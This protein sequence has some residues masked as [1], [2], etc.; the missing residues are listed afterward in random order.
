MPICFPNDIVWSIKHL[1]S[2]LEYTQKGLRTHFSFSLGF[3]LVSTRIGPYRET[4]QR[5]CRPTSSLG[6]S[7]WHALGRPCLNS[8]HI[9]FPNDILWSIKH[10]RS[11][12]EYTQQGLRTYLSVLKLILDWKSLRFTG[13]RPRAEHAL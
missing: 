3:T 2:K 5:S 4:C 1:R 8:I 9:C 12:L 11:K 10:L 13:L 6:L 7:L